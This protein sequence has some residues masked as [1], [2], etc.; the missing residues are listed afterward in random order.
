M[1]EQRAEGRIKQPKMDKN[2]TKKTKKRR[3]R[4]I[5]PSHRLSSPFWFLQFLCCFVSNWSLM[6]RMTNHRF[7]FLFYVSLH[8]FSYSHTHTHMQI[9]NVC[10]MILFYYWANFLSKFWLFNVKISQIFGFFLSISQKF[11]FKVKIAQFL[12]IIFE[13]LAF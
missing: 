8:F 5:D 6:T 12:L 7:S 11:G 2:N 1:D 10:L 4:I 3:K 13:I 9:F